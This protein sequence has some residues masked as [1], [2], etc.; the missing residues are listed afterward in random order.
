MSMAAYER[1]STQSEARVLA[2]KRCTRQQLIM[3]SIENNFSVHTFLPQYG[4][5]VG[6]LAFY[7]LFPNESLGTKN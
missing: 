5:T 4:I 1:W 2:L 7:S 6:Q 3:R